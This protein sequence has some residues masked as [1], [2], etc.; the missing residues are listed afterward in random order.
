VGESRAFEVSR[1]MNSDLS[2]YR[3]M[4]ASIIGNMFLDLETPSGSGM[5]LDH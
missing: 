1:S 5:L 4:H 2:T 3:H